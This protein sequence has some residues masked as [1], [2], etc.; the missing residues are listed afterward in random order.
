MIPKHLAFLFLLAFSLWTCR[1]K[2]VN[3]RSDGKD[4]LIE[5]VLN[6]SSLSFV[7]T[8][9]STKGKLFFETKIPIYC[10]VWYGT[11]DPLPS[12]DKEVN[13]LTCGKEKLTKFALDVPLIDARPPTS[14]KFFFWV[15][16][17]KSGKF[18]YDWSPSSDNYPFTK[19]AITRFDRIIKISQTHLH[20]CTSCR[21][22]MVYES[23]Q[24]NLGCYEKI[25]MNTFPFLTSDTSNNFKALASKGFATNTSSEHPGDKGFFLTRFNTL[26]EGDI[27]SWT[28]RMNNK[29]HQVNISTPDQ[30]LSF[31]LIQNER[32]TSMRKSNLDSAP[33]RINLDRQ[34]PL[35]L[36]WNNKI[37][38]NTSYISFLVG[39]PKSNKSFFCRFSAKEKTGTIEPQFFKDLPAAQNIPIFVRQSSYHIYNIPN[40]PWSRML[41]SSHDWRKGEFIP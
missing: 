28:F 22:K 13:T 41:I 20:N 35:T 8:E 1:S 33:T 16:E 18:A 4:A 17:D 24:Q 25:D 6:R 37:S 12:N 19:L 34:K 29:D 14:F 26:Q 11:K 32:S 36:E 31:S 15:N 9:D 10:E 38:S 21:N 40:E 7:T 30:I 39:D 27:W 2:P 23:L 3:L 5:T